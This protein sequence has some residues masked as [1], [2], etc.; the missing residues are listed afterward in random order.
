MAVLYHG[1][2]SLFAQ[3][4]IKNGLGIVQSDNKYD[5]IRYILSK[6]INPQILTDEFFDK[7]AQYISSGSYSSINI[8]E[9]QREAGNG[10]FGV[11]LFKLLRNPLSRSSKLCKINNKFWC[12][13]I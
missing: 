10:P 5:E 4:I 8:R 7:Y 6:Y 2:S 1:T 3:D 12:G 11:F 13:R 9:S